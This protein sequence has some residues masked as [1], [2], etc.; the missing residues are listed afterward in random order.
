MPACCGRPWARIRA[1]PVRCSS[2]S[3]IEIDRNLK[4]WKIPG[5]V[6][7][8]ATLLMSPMANLGHHVLLLGLELILFPFHAHVGELGAKMRVES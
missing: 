3:H 5:K 6:A 8:V 2:L 7:F 4:G 1:Y